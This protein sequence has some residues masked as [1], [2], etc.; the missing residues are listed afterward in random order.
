M[1]QLSSATS[2]EDIPSEIRGTPVGLLLEYHNLHRPFSE[3][4]QAQLLVGMCMDHR[5]RLR[6]PDNFAYIIRAGGANL[7][8]SDFFVSFAIG[9]G[10]VSAIALIGHTDCGMVNLRSRQEEFIAG[11]E[12]R[13]EWDRGVAEEYFLHNAPKYEIGN[14]ADFILSESKRLRRSYPGIEVVPMIY[15]VEDNL[16]YLITIGRD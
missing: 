1:Y 14:E 8:D 7:G 15:R 10:G 4:S 2:I 9:V 16:L 5:K 13:G 12:K 3:Y 6:I 11:L